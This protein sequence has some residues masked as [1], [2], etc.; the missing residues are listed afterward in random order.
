MS[1][2]SVR[3]GKYTGMRTA[4]KKVHLV[5]NGKSPATLYP[6]PSAPQ[7]SCLLQNAT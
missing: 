1:M 6:L 4:D 5:V 2:Y 7:P 3:F